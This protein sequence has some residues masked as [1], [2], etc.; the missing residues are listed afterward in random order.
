MVKPLLGA[1]DSLPGV[2][3]APSPAPQP[4]AQGLGNYFPTDNALARYLGVLSGSAVKLYVNLKKH[5]NRRVVP[6][7][8]ARGYDRL[9]QDLGLSRRMVVYAEQEVEAQGLIHKQALKE[10]SGEN[11]R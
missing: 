9:A 2:L 4:T 5:A 10:Q 11:L 8:C 1:Q 6:E 7:R 3:P